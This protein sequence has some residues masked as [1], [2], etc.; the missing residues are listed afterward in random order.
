MKPKYLYSSRAVTE[1][2][3]GR[4]PLRG[5]RLMSST[6]LLSIEK[7]ESKNPSNQSSEKVQRKKQTVIVIQPFKRVKDSTSSKTIDHILSRVLEAV[8]QV[9][10]PPPGGLDAGCCPPAMETPDQLEPE[11]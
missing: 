2:D 4:P 3:P 11:G 8:S 9:P 5:P 6:S 1:Q 10:K 7:L